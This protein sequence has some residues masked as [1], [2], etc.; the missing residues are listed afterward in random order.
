MQPSIVERKEAKKGRL[1]VIKGEVSCGK[2][3]HMEA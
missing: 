3:P 1:Q 2:A